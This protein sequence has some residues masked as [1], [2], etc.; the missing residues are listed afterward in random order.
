MTKDRRPAPSPPIHFP[1]LLDVG[2]LAF[3]RSK[4]QERL[5]LGRRPFSSQG[6]ARGIPAGPRG[7]PQGVA[8]LTEVT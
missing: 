8:G 1:L 4:G 3:L 6:Q 2:A 5:R 7:F